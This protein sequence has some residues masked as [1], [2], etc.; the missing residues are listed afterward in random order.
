VQIPTQRSRI[1]SFHPEG[2]IMRPDA[3]QY[4][5]DSQ[6]SNVHPSRRHGN[7]SGRTLEFNKYSDFLH[8]HV[9]EKTAASIR[10]IGQHRLDEVFNKARHGKELQPSRR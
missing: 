2:P 10:A 4:L 9:Y 5:E 6:Y 1:L 7:T 3:H 8:R